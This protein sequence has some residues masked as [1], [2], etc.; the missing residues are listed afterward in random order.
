MGFID[1]K[2]SHPLLHACLVG[3][4]YKPSF[5]TITGKQVNPKK[6]VILSVLVSIFSIVFPTLSRVKET[7]WPKFI[8]ICPI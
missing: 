1:K 3:D 2:D 8:P 5:V 7:K 6:K 4:S